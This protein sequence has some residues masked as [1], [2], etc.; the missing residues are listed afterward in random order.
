MKVAECWSQALECAC[1]LAHS[2]LYCGL[3]ACEML[4]AAHPLLSPVYPAVEVVVAGP[5]CVRAC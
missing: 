2:A 1:D 5:A 4:A 3:G